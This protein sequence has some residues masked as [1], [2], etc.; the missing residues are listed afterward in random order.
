M[1]IRKNY[2]SL[3]DE[4]RDRFVQAL[5]HLKSTGVVDQLAEIHARH[6]N[7]GIHRSSHFL[8]WHREMLFRFEDALR[9]HHPD[10][11]IPYWDSTVDH[12]PSDPLWS[13]N[14]LG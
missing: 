1:F 14:F 12:S 3:T 8:P 2:R 6:F 11:T 13:N 7:H 5:Y 10:V 9:T 4:E